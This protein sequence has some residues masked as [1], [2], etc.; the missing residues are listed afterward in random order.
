M[1]TTVICFNTALCISF[2]LSSVPGPPVRLMFPE[3]R[4]TSVRVVWQPPSEPNG[5]IM[6]KRKHK[7]HTPS[8]TNI[9]SA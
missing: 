9:Q 8:Y 5:I 2:P 1:R 4:L 7:P 3:V 6:G